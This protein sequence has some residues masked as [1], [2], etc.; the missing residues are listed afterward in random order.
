LGAFE[1]GLEVVGVSVGP[2]GEEPLDWGGEGLVEA[3]E[4]GVV[5]SLPLRLHRNPGQ[6]TSRISLH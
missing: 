5:C 2:A 4:V 6:L 3:V 1:Q